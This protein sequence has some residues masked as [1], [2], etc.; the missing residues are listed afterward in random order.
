VAET[1][2]QARRELFPHFKKIRDR[3]GKERG[4]P[5]VTEED[6]ENEI[7]HGSLYAGSPETVANKIARTV[8]TLGISRFQ[9]KYSA[10]PMEHEKLMQSVELYG[11]K[12]ITLVRDSLW[13]PPVELLL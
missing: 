2:E 10:G 9:M 8:K 7:E 12:V 11:S 6:F 1:D 3:L 4:W 5:P 13:S